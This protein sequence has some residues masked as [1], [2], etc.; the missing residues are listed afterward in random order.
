VIGSTVRC[1]G[2]AGLTVGEPNVVVT[3][4]ASP[5]VVTSTPVASNWSVGLSSSVSVTLVAV[6]LAVSSAPAGTLAPSVSVIVPSSTAMPVQLTWAACTV[7]E[8]DELSPSLD[9]VVASLTV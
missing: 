1:P 2:A 7:H 4:S 9:T 3:V 5:P 8:P 6:H